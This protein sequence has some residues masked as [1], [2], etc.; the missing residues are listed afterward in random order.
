MADKLTTLP[1]PF[2]TRM[3]EALR[4]L[5]HPYRLRVVE[6]LDRT[7]PE[8]VHAIA[9]ALGGTQGALSQHLTRMRAAGIIRAERRGKEVWYA[10]ANP[11]SLTILNCMRKRYSLEDRK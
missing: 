5:A 11:D 7:G 8:P 2:M 1:E 4:V 3:A 10:I 9:R 6:H